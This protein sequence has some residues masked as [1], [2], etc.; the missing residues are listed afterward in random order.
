MTTAERIERF[1]AQPAI[2]VVGVSRSGKKFGNVAVRELRAKGY[3]VFPIHPSAPA[4]NGVPCFRSFRDLPDKVDAAL[5]VVPPHA[6]LDV[7]RDATAARI[8]HVWLQQ[9]AESPEVLAL[10]DQ[11]G[12]E[13]VAGECILLFARPSGIHRAHHWVR[14]VCGTLP[15]GAP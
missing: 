1:I 14:R 2:A 13:T 12:V 7:V 4:V 8:H 10:C 5:I 9:G 6:A 11:L 3:R 15:V